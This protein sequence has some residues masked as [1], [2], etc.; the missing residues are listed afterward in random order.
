MNINLKPDRCDECGLQMVKAHRVHKEHRY[1]VTCYSR[2]FKRLMCPKCGNLARLLKNDEAAVC[3]ACEN[4]KPC[5]R[6]SKVD[7]AI[8]KIT[9]YGP[10]CNACA[11]HFRKPEPCEVC[12]E[13]ST[14][15]T[16]LR[17]VNHDHRMCPKCAVADQG[18]CQACRRHRLLQASTDG[19]MLC[20]ACLE[21]GEIPCPKCLMPM[22]AGYGKQCQRCYWRRLAEKRV[23]M[24]CSAFDAS[25]MASHF[26]AFGNWLLDQ[27]G[28]QKTALTIHDYLPFFLEI[29]KQWK[30]IPTYA[31]LLTHFGAAKLRRVLLPVQWMEVADLVVS[32]EEAKV[33]DSDRRRIAATLNSLA[34]G[35]KA[36]N[37]LDGYHSVLMKKLIADQTTLR[38]IRLALTPAAALL[39]MA[40]E[41]K[42]MPPDQSV[43]KA[44]L[45]KTPGQRA[46]VSGF[47]RHLR[48]KC[49]VEI[50]LLKAEPGRANQQRRKKLEMEMTALMK[51]PSESRE[52]KQ[53]WL[54]I[55]LAYFHGLNRRVGVAIAETCVKYADDGLT[56]EWDGQSYWVPSFPNHV[57]AK[58]ED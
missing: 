18:T 57:L 5:V 39:N 8:G 6:C 50:F 31:Q 56:V 30:D 19:R 35:A 49:G 10:V 9:A 12:G 44:Y 1:C 23:Q 36:R 42:Q 51:E 53:R 13:F 40:T 15:L 26:E 37:L 47:V 48:D 58:H 14:R 25:K 28:E 33:A 32:D 2:V 29:E 27:V 11:H 21:K 3:R 41:M 20:H 16:R 22:P 52:F 43:L 38:S 46:A 45:A 24:D 7:Y 55:A 54:S 4:K 17:R 34:N